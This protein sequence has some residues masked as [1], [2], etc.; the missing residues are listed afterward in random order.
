MGDFIATGAEMVV[1]ANPG[2]L[3]QLDWGRK[4]GGL[5]VAVKHLVQVLDESLGQEHSAD[6]GL[7]S[8]AKPE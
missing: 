7:K 4:R 1:S 3:M 8:T 6:D 5:K 2:C